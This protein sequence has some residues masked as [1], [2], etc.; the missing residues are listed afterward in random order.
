MQQ[1]RRSAMICGVQKMANV[2]AG[3]GIYIFDKDERFREFHQMHIWRKSGR[4]GMEIENAGTCSSSVVK[5]RDLT[6]MRERSA[7]EGPSRYDNE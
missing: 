1:W 3:V 5:N 7:I 4:E 6:R 2:D